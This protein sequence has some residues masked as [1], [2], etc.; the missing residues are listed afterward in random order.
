VPK[1][2]PPLPGGTIAAALYQQAFT[3]Q[4]LLSRRTHGQWHL[5]ACPIGQWIGNHSWPDGSPCGG[6]CAAL[7]AALHD[8]AVVLG[9]PPGDW[10]DAPLAP[11]KSP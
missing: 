1:R 9:L 10:L 8:S 5:P 3:A 6:R 11:R 4:C 2:P 7:R